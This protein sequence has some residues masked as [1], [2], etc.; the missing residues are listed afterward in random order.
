[1]PAGPET[2]GNDLANFADA[3]FDRAEAEAAP[4]AAATVAEM[5]TAGISRQI[6][7]FIARSGKRILVALVGGAVLLAGVAMLVLPGPALVVIPAGLA[8]LAT[9]FAWAKSALDRAKEKAQQAKDLA[10]GGDPARARFINIA[11][12]ALM[13]VGVCTGIWWQFIR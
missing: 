7:R 6:V 2:D 3:I 8:I 9:E 13:V 11:G 1:M 4:D 5:P 10:S 12:I